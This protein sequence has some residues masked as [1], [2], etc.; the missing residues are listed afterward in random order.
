MATRIIVSNSTPLI[1]FATISEL[2]LLRKLFNHVY[3][4]QAV[5]QE[6]VI[7]G[8][9][10]SA[11]LIERTEWIS[12][13]SITQQR[14]C[15]SLNKELDSGEAEAIVLAIELNADLI[16]LDESE[17][18]NFAESQGLR[19]MGSIGCLTLAKSLGLIARVKPLLDKMIDKSRFWVSKDLYEFVLQDNQEI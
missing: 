19:Y 1:N 2:D 16:L 18:R 15:D 11:I 6:V 12:K 7:R 8:W 14:L 3:V 4:P 17:A 13:T 5:W 9:R 10:E